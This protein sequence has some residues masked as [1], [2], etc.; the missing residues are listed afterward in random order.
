MGPILI[1]LDIRCHNIIYNPD[2]PIILRTTHIYTETRVRAF[3]R[4]K[5]SRRSCEILWSYGGISPFVDIR[6]VGR[7]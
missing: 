5:G 7:D 3:L 6:T 4:V 1:P 2:V